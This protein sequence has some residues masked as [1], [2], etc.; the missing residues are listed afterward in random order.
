MTELEL[1]LNK[2][3]YE[4]L[5][6]IHKECDKD[7]EPPLSARKNIEAYCRK[8]VD[9]AEII[10]VC[11]DG[12]TAGV[13]CV[14]END[15]TSRT[16]FVSSVIVLPE[17]R[18]LGLGNLLVDRAITISEKRKMARIRLEVG[19]RNRAALNLYRKYGFEIENENELSY[20]MAREC[21]GK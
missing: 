8:L 1:R 13:L 12:K 17:Y 5:Y 21:N 16:A 3:N 14:Y 19:K 6:S 7:F 4:E 11:F 9:N 18:R 15:S 20:M 10:S 2:V